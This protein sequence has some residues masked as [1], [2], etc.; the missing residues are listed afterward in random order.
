[1]LK[2]RL[3]LLT[4]ASA[5]DIITPEQA[6][7]IIELNGLFDTESTTQDEVWLRKSETMLVVLQSCSVQICDEKH[8]YWTVQIDQ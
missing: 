5:Q 8:V 1:M 4:P 7:L 6:W 3:Y 2:N